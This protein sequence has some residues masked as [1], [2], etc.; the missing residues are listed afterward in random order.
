[1]W[2]EEPGVSIPWLNELIDA[3]SHAVDWVAVCTGERDLPGTVA[4]ETPPVFEAGWLEL[5]SKLQVTMFIRPTPNAEWCDDYLVKLA[6]ASGCRAIVGNE[7]DVL[8]NLPIDRTLP[9]RRPDVWSKAILGFAETTHD[10]SNWVVPFDIKGLWMTAEDASFL[11]L[12]T[13]LSASGEKVSA[14]SAQ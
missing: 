10:R 7:S 2:I 1:M 12:E 14:L 13:C 9:S 6:V 5:I 11:G 8:D 4:R 3:T